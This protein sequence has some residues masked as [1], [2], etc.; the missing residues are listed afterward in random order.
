MR[1]EGIDETDLCRD[2]QKEE[3]RETTSVQTHPSKLP[4]IRNKIRANSVESTYGR[5]V[6]ASRYCIDCPDLLLRHSLAKA[7]RSSEVALKLETRALNAWLEEENLAFAIKLARSL[8][9]CGSPLDHFGV[10]HAAALTP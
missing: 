4:G 9:E 1:I 8:A 6:A 7:C 5:S 2:F 10:T 3:R